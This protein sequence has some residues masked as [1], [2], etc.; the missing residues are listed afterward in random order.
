MLKEKYYNYKLDYKNYILLIKSG[1]FYLALDNDAFIMSKVFNYKIKESTNL[2]K[3]GFPITSLTK[4]T[5]R[6]NAEEINYLIINENKII[7]KVKQKNNK[8][9]SYSFSHSNYSIYMGRINKITEIL[10]SNIGS[11]KIENILS[12]IEKIICKIDY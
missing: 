12:E 10:K 9:S 6:L 2:I 8:Y 4:V 5:E 11:S 1:N 3:I 7:E